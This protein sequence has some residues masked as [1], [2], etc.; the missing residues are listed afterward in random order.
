MLFLKKSV[1]LY[2]G[3]KTIQ[4]AQL[5]YIAGKVH[6]TNFV[7]VDIFEDVQDTNKSLD[8]ELIL[9]ALRKISYKS[10]IDLRKVNTVLLP[11]MVLLRYFQMPYISAEEMEEA[12]RFEAK[13]YIPFKLEEAVTGFY[14]LRGKK[15]T[16]KV[17]IISLVTKGEFI[18]N[19]LAMLNK[20]NITPISIETASFA[21]LRFLE[22]SGEIEIKKS[23]AVV[24]FYEQRVNIIILKDGIPYFVR[25]VSL[26]KKEEW[27]DDETAEL[28]IGSKTA[29]P[30][31]NRL[32]LLD[33]VLSDVKISL[34]YYKKELGKE[35]VSKVILCGELD[36]FDSLFAPLNTAAEGSSKG[37]SSLPEYLSDK[38]NVS[39]KTIDPFKTIQC[40]K[41]K[42]LP[43]TFPMFPVTLGTALRGLVKTRIEIDLFRARKKTSL[44]TK[45]LIR[46]M[47]L[48]EVA[49]LLVS[50]LI[51]QLVFSAF[52]SKEQKILKKI[53][54]SGS[55][56]V[57]VSHFDQKQLKAGLDSIESRINIYNK[58]VK[59]KVY[60]TPKLSC[61]PKLTNA[62]IWLTKL[63]FENSFI[64]RRDK[65]NENSFN[66][67]I[68]GNVFT[69]QKGTEVEMINEYV[70]KLK[71]DVAFFKGFKIIKTGS[72]ERSSFGDMPIM[73]F[74]LICSSD[75][76]KK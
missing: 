55:K 46:K 61:L 18:K 19:H 66:L 53:R 5:Q 58:L 73:T 70:E 2:V 8:A 62:E 37:V 56:F 75:L 72:V 17:G 13:K 16:R 42:P 3:T 36:Y 12:V 44:K 63:N 31:D 40:V 28:L 29:I 22:Y 43:H 50:F 20:V 11:G 35:S 65:S 52:V 69:A 49:A 15:E 7:H 33:D 67:Q 59:E 25:D 39:V 24:Y 21:L 27:I 45:I 32:T 68:K 14:I 74:D 41:T 1:G 34:E 71:A 26:S 57:E 38:L 30:A 64:V 51:M 4:L 47:V 76:D 54:N 60:L 48:I 6:L 10:K 9:K 23:N